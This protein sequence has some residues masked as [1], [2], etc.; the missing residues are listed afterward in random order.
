MSIQ[1]VPIDY[2]VTEEDKRKYDILDKLNYYYGEFQNS[3][4]LEVIDKK[5]IDNMI[6]ELREQFGIFYVPP[7]Y[8]LN[9]SKVLAREEYVDL[10]DK[11]CQ[12][13]T[14]RNMLLTEFNIFTTKP[15]EIKE[16]ISRRILG[17]CNLANKDREEME[18]YRNI[19]CVA[20]GIEDMSSWKTISEKVSKLK[21]EV[22]S[23]TTMMIP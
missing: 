3:P 21:A 7:H 16:E 22:E 23:L 13:Q 19:M 11:E 1:Y 2:T 4:M 9:E 17:A 15:K 20:L 14:I 18:Q 6:T 5:V 8:D 12:L 10:K